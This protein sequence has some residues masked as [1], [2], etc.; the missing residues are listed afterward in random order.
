MSLH[1]PGVRFV[2]GRARFR[3]VSVSALLLGVGCA[4]HDSGTSGGVEDGVA[5]TQAA[6]VAPGAPVA[7]S[8]AYAIELP[9]DLTLSALAV[10]GGQLEIGD[11]A[12]IK[13][14]AGEYAPVGSVGPATLNVGADAKTGRI[15]SKSDVFLRE[16][17]EV[18]GALVTAGVVQKQNGTTVT[19]TVKE[20]QS[21]VT[22]TLRRRADFGART[23]GISLEPNVKR[24]QPVAP[25]NYATLTLKTGSEATLIAGEYF[26][27]EI[28]IEP[29]A[30]LFIDNTGGTTYVLSNRLTNVKGNIAGKSGGYPALLLSYLGTTEALISAAFRGSIVAPNGTL[31]LAPVAGNSHQGTFIAKKVVVAADTAIVQRP[32]PWVDM[33]VSVSKPQV[34]S[35]ESF[36]VSVVARDSADPTKVPTILIDGAPSAQAW[37]QPVG[38]VG[39][40][41]VPVS[42]TMSDG[43]VQSQLASVQVVACPNASSPNPILYGEAHIYDAD[44]VDF[45]LGN[46]EE[47]E[48]GTASYSW[49]FGD[50]TTATSAAGAI[51]HKYDWSQDPNQRS[52][53][54]DVTVT[55][56]R[57]GLPDVSAT[58]TFVVWNTYA[59]SKARGAIEPPTSLA[60]PVLT[61]QGANLMAEVTF[62]NLE[63][64][65]LTFTR[66]RIDRIACDAN[67]NIAYGSEETTSL[68]VPAKGQLTE[69]FSL[70]AAGVDASICAVNVHYWGTAAGTRAQASVQLDVPARFGSGVPVPELGN[71]L[72]NHV[73]DA[74]LVSNPNLITEE[75]LHAVYRD[76]K[77]RYSVTNNVF[78]QAA[79]PAD[80][81]CDPDN[82]G[83][84]PSSGF[85]CQASGQWETES[86][87]GPSGAHIANAMK[88][89][90]VVVRSCSGFIKTL[91][92]KVDPPQVWTHSGIMT[93]NRYEVT[94]STGHDGWLEAHP[95]GSFDEPTD[96]FEEQALRYLWPGTLTSTV[97]EA[98]DTGR[99]V[100]SPDGDEYGVRGFN[101]SEARCNGDRNIVYPRVVKPAPEMDALVRPRL[102]A[103]ADASKTIRGHYRFGTYSAAQATPANDPNGPS[104][105]DN[106]DGG[107]QTYGAVP[108]VCS[109]L[110]RLALIA[111]G[112]VVDANKTLP[113]PGDVQGGP[114]DGLFFY[115]SDER[116][117]AADALYSSLY[118]KVVMELEK[119]EAKTDDYWWASAGG[120]ALLFGAPGAALGFL[121]TE[122]TGTTITWATDAPDDVANQVVNCFASDYCS[123][124][125]KD[126]ERWQDP[127]NGFSVSPD[128]IVNYYD[129]PN[130]DGSGGVYGY[131]E[132]LV[133]RGKRFRPK[134][135]WQPAPGTRTLTG[136]VLE[137]DGT[138]A[139]LASVE[140]KGTDKAATTDASGR[141]S[142]VAAP[143]GNVFLHAQKWTGPEN[144]GE[145]RE[146]DACYVP[147]AS[148]PDLLLNVDCQDFATP[149]GSPAAAEVT[150]KL[151]GRDQRFRK[152]IITGTVRMN[153]C[154]CCGPA[155]CPDVGSAT[156]LETCLVSPLQREDTFSVGADQICEDEVGVSVSGKCTLLPDD[157]TVLVE[158]TNKLFEAGS[159]S[160]GG[161]EEEDSQGFSHQVT[162]DASVNIYAPMLN[163]SGECPFFPF[164]FDCSDTAQFDTF[165]AENKVAE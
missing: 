124:D 93:N 36:R 85:S 100:R 54:M 69:P 156:F 146:G 20:R 88:G 131:H 23:G 52:R 160:C 35:G 147:D 48:D 118:N 81:P 68:T 125:A 145:L 162:A 136:T 138:P 92:A 32:I 6:L 127:G 4:A 14:S 87:G 154:D 15:V 163:N 153:D 42:A 122:T 126:S 148:A 24:V 134:F 50:G 101:P 72:L 157:R 119:L 41:L 158:G 91:M 84:P 56:K 151:G 22:R 90:T 150:I 75:E 112:T 58:R 60:S 116:K 133:Y 140:L 38:G 86:S 155:T 128:D 96:G 107:S 121:G 132:R 76:R 28:N 70:P 109:Q 7:L 71:R 105:I 117:A 142:I 103:A 16:R 65:A 47:F 40:R 2:L 26:F 11:R 37:D 73:V 29:G 144:T 44:V 137:E 98:F 66:R 83:S 74:G 159:D 97:E 149:L 18:H 39:K 63:A 17:A 108:T 49:S 31:H 104:P 79:P 5:Q 113:T 45:T 120:G 34:C 78:Y 12:S 106:T 143:G 3:S 67:A 13:T 9:A 25:G 135:T 141:F 8:V 123:E 64:S 59:L 1:L 99:R 102:Q 114:A 161:N 10:S 51:S 46:P 80:E 53:A 111:D 82:P 62:K 95:N 57:S 21:V 129:A 110:V 89:D 55:V 30:K 130:A 33:V 61:A 164:P 43:A 77:V 165:K 19:G 94:Q 152:V 27:D 139:A 115:D